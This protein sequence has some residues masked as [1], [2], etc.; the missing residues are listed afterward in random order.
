MNI[1]KLSIALGA[2]VIAAATGGVFTAPAI[3]DWYAGLEKPFF[4][5]PNEVFS[6]VWILLYLSMA[7]ASYR[8]WTALD[9]TVHKQPARRE[10]A[11]KHKRSHHNRHRMVD[12][13]LHWYALQLVLNPL[14]SIAFFGFRS[15]LAGMIVIVLFLAAVIE[16]ILLFRKIDGIAAALMVPLALWVSFAMLL[17][18]E[19]VLM[20]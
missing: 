20:N 18:I 5:P 11:E 19:I 3:P 17:N 6:P 7:I 12:A 10:D 9:G 15:P 4:T 2:V 13:A 8:V 16:T 1:K 14:W